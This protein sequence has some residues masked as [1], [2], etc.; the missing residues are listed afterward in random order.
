MTSPGKLKV[1][2]VDQQ[3]VFADALVYRLQSETDLEVVCSASDGERAIAAVI[4]S[5]PNVVV[6]DAGLSGGV[7]FDIAAEV[8][9]RLPAAR[10]VFLT[11]S[12]ADA[13]IDQAL[14]VNADAI[15]SRNEPLADLVQAI[16]RTAYSE[17]TFSPGIRSKIDFDP[18]ERQFRLRVDA[19]TKVL[20][21]RQVEILRYLARG[22]S[23]KSVARKLFLSPKS[24]DNQ[25]FRIMSKIG[26]RDKVSLAL[27]A[28][29]EGLIEP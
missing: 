3:R 20:T 19:P 16:R 28:I 11:H 22:E 18:V 21:D 17:P 7:A 6:L 26:V 13:L 24:V 8:R 4:D 23:V 25:K 15:L 14:R 2:I 1:A 9:R 29:R 12:A 10:L 5:R 27:Y